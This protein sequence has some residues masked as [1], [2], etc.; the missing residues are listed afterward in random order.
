MSSVEQAELLGHQGI[1][2][3]T[4]DFDIFR[5]GVPY[6]PRRSYFSGSEAVRGFLHFMREGHVVRGAQ[7]AKSKS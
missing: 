6:L 5:V 7:Q 2:L 3:V 4:D 1:S